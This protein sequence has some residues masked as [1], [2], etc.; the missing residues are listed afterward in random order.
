M[1]R[2]KIYLSSGPTTTTTQS[3]QC[4]GYFYKLQKG[5]GDLGFVHLGSEFFL[6]Q[7]SNFDI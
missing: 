6:M 3:T 4:K 2:A 7:N 1:Y 5:S